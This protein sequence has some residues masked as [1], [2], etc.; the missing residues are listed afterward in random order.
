LL[1][2]HFSNDILLL[3]FKHNLDYDF[4]DEVI[5]I[6]D[7][8]MKEEIENDKTVV[9]KNLLDITA[10]IDDFIVFLHRQEP[11]TTSRLRYCINTTQ[12]QK[13]LWRFLW[14]SLLHG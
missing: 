4:A 2:D 1:R 8:F 12:T 10:F 7:A 9:E 11:I 13:T 5:R 3:L 14:A 6:L